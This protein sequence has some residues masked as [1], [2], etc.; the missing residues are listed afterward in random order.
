MDK[1]KRIRRKQNEEKQW[2]EM[3]A[4]SK[5]GPFLEKI[6]AA[7]RDA[8]DSSA[9]PDSVLLWSDVWTSDCVQGL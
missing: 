8:G 1:M 5:D 4:L 9:F 6:L 3:D 7:L 2:Q